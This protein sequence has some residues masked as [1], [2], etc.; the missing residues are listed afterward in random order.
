MPQ[1]STGDGKAGARDEMAHF[2][3]TA[4]CLTF[5]AISRSHLTGRTPP[6]RKALTTLQPFRFNKSHRPAVGHKR[7]ND[8]SDETAASQFHARPMPDFSRVSNMVIH[9][10]PSRR[11]K[12]KRKKRTNSRPGR[13]QILAI[14]DDPILPRPSRIGPVPKPR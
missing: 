5:P 13:C 8:G 2:Q 9:R 1:G 3:G 6:A 7:K 4:K 10:N 11:P 12:Q 14:R